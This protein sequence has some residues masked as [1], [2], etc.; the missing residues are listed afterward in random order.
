MGLLP[1]I[2]DVIKRRTLSIFRLCLYQGT[3]RWLR[4]CLTSVDG[5]IDVNLRK[6][7]KI[8]FEPN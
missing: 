7:W 6:K 3:A 4:H 1:L 2:S 8:L 5:K